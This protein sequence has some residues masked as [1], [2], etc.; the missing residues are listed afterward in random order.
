MVWRIPMKGQVKGS[1]DF[2]LPLKDYSLC[3]IIFLSM[4]TGQEWFICV[5]VSTIFCAQ[6]RYAY[7][8]RSYLPY[9]CGL[10]DV[11]TWM[12][13]KKCHNLFI[14]NCPY[15]FHRASPRTS[16]HIVKTAHENIHNRLTSIRDVLALT[17]LSKVI[18]LFNDS[19]I[20]RFISR[21]HRDHVTL[22]ALF[23]T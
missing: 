12:A 15:I 22:S 17:T 21:A 23:Y 11:L 10:S 20:R 6:Y 14:Y 3:L 5:L 8:L 4:L 18:G 7:M 1:R 16:V 9:I 13:N 2:G 19:T